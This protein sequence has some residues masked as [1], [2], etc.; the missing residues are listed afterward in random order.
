M[1]LFDDKV[2]Q[3]LT[4]FLNTMNDTVNIVYF[5]QEFECRLCKETRM[6]VEE[7][8]ELSDK[9]DLTVYDFQ[10]ES[11]KAEEYGVDKIPA[12]VILD[13]DKKDTGIKFYGLPGGYE[14]NSFMASLLET[15]GRKEEIPADIASR[16]AGIDKDV[17]IQVF[18]TLQCPYC[19]A[20]VA[21]AHRLALDNPKIKGDMVDS[22]VFPH[23]ANRYE[24][25]SVPRIIIND[26]HAL[27][28]AQPLT[29]ILDVI[30]HV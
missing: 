15:S 21:A 1:A 24:V 16:I 17:H 25:T 22:A 18:I 28:G 6:F 2:K 7:I 30:D 27:E 3:Q 19:P 11:K 14:I 4:E 13:K 26:T 23:L 9:V 29:A 5:T 10:K 8:S 12:I 20:A